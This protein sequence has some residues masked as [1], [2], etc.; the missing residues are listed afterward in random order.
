MKNTSERTKREHQRKNK[1][2]RCSF[3]KRRKILARKKKKRGVG[4]GYLELKFNHTSLSPYTAHAFN[5][6]AQTRTK[7]RGPPLT[8]LLVSHLYQKGGAGTPP[9][10]E[11]HIL[12]TV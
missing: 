4:G 3:N 8:L 5:F 9:T 11:Y 2:R 12:R 10:H 1:G 6:A 7:S